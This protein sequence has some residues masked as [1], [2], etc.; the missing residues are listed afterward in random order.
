MSPPQTKEGGMKEAETVCTRCLDPLRPL[1]GAR[2]YSKTQESAMKLLVYTKMLT[3]M[4]ASASFFM[5][6]HGFFFEMMLCKTPHKHL[7]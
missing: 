4:N 2:V 3:D 6:I 7:Q 1:V 5:I